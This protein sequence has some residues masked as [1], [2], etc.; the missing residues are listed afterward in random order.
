MRQRVNVARALAIAPTFLLMDEPFS[1]LDAQ[2]RELMQLELLRVWGEAQTGVIFVTHMIEEAVFLADRVLVLGARPG[3]VRRE[4]RVALARPR[5]LTIKREPEFQRLC[6]LIWK[7]IEE[8]V[9]TGMLIEEDRD[10]QTALDDGR[11]PRRDWLRR[12]RR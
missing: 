8:D 7:E 9:K 12:V 10:E 5:P 6:D 1:A 11:E 4:V 2:T 3:R